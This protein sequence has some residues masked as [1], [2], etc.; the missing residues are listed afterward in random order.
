MLIEISDGQWVDPKT[1]VAVTVSPITAKRILLR[2][3]V[4]IQTAQTIVEVWIVP[5]DG[6]NESIV[7]C[8]AEVVASIVVE[9]INR[10][11]D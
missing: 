3:L 2:Y 7:R 9:K 8:R 11:L 4:V 5:L 1:V 6:E 10:H